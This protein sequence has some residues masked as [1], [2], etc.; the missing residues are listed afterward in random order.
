[1]GQSLS[2]SLWRHLEKCTV[3]KAKKNEGAG[4]HALIERDP[5]VLLCNGLQCLNTVKV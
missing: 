3:I 1:M 5:T 2:Y 4:R